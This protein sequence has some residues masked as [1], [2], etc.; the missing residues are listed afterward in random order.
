MSAFPFAGLVEGLV[1]GLLAVPVEGLVDVPVEGL[2]VGLAADAGLST[3]VLGLT[4]VFTDGFSAGFLTGFEGLAT[5][6]FLLLSLD[7]GL[8]CEPDVALLDC[9]DCDD[10]LVCEDDDLVCEDCEDLLVCAPASDMNAANART[11]SIDAIV[12]LSDPMI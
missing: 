11:A 10:D 5:V 6:D 12:F 8:V 2:V 7:D 3:V 4:L 1:A 9:D